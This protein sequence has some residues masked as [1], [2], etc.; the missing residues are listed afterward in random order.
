M[1]DQLQTQLPT[2]ENGDPEIQV[3]FA[4]GWHVAEYRHLAYDAGLPPQPGYLLK[5][6]PNLDHT[7]RL[8]LLAEQIAAG[9]YALHIEPM[10]LTSTNEATSDLRQAKGEDLPTVADIHVAMLTRLMGYKEK[11]ARSYLAGVGLAQTVIA[12]Y[13]ITEA[14]YAVAIAEMND[15]ARANA[16][17]PTGKTAA[18][19]PTYETRAI[20]HP[21]AAA[22]I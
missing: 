1:G 20:P 12:A 22:R 4:L 7:E 15:E 2:I 3:A 18:D 14:P 17:G 9:R 21:F 10:P 19:T 8:N 5:Q 16:Q 13:K 6:I 11:V